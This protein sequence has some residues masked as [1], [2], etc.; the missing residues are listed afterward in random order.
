MKIAGQTAIVTG[1]ASGM[2]EATAAALA[3]G[4]AK[5]ALFDVK[6]DVVRA[7]AKRVGGLDVVCD[8]SDAASTE[9][10]F[11]AVRQQLGPARILVNCAGIP[12]FA[13]VVGPDGPLPLER[14]N[15][16]I[17]V[18]LSGTF[19]TIRLAAAEMMGL[20]PLDEGERG[21]IINTTSIA[22]TEGSE[23]TAAY[24][25]SKGAIHSLTIALAREFGDAGIRVLAIAPAGIRT[26]MMTMLPPQAQQ[27]IEGT[28]PFPKRLADPKVFAK[29]VLHIC[30]NTFL[31]GTA[32]R[33]DGGARGA[34][35][36][37]KPTGD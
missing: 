22:A 29:L 2:G 18:N 28:M 15:R 7:T 12:D 26:P 4:G 1:A 6:A 37:L 9:A 14:F 19:N 34:Y 13:P 21:V 25:A 10:A 24:T 35:K 32:I 5:V 8:V 33:L 27:A 31:N 20:A 11:A 23:F 3:A 30:D 17:A 36:V 16:V